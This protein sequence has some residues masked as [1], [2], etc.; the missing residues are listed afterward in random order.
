MSA[1]A[2]LQ[3]AADLGLALLHSCWQIALLAGLLWGLRT[4]LHRA[5]PDFHHALAYTVLVL[6]VAWPMASFVQQRVRRQAQVR[7]RQVGTAQ[8]LPAM[9]R[10]GLRR[11]R[12]GLVV[13]RPAL[14]WLG[15]LW[16]VGCVSFAARL[17]GGGLLLRRQ[18]R[19]S[20]AAPEPL[21]RLAENLARRMGMAV[22][23]LRI[24]VQGSGPYCYGLF[25]AVVV[26]PA[27]CLAHLDSIALEAVLAHELAHLRRLDYLLNGIQCVLELLV[28]HH[29]LAWWIS[30]VVR[31]ERERCCDEAAV[32]V[33]GDARS[34]ATALLQLDELRPPQPALSAHGA[35]VFLRIKH[36]LGASAQ[37]SRFS[38]V[39]AALLLGGLLLATPGLRA[40]G[41]QTIVRAPVALVRLADAAAQAEGL[42]PYLVRAMIQCESRY[43]PGA[44]SKAGAQGLLQL[45]P[46]TAAKMGGGDMFDPAANLRAGTKFMHS[47]LEHYKG[48][49]ALAVMAYNAGPEAV[50]QAEGIAPTG[51]S[52]VYALAVMDLYRRKAVEADAAL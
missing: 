34:F 35:P 27:A 20:G 37:P 44:V 49:T 39:S 18:R 47:L 31:F 11:M 12:Q 41:S 26:L 14:P 43:L 45:I 52:R 5:S 38:L 22:P 19:A 10:P 40:E 42:D 25:H 46:A 15:V 48:N 9:V 29:P 28:F 51:E 16:L 13:A 3:L 2:F 24:A 36:L 17:C 30:S 8:V 4:L 7:V 32:R 23:E 1:A 21:L 6:A 50:D 33:C